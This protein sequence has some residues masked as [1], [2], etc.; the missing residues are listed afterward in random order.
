MSI[1]KLIK[2]VVIVGLGV[3]ILFFIYRKARPQEEK[4]LFKTEPLQ[5]RTITQVIDS[6]GTLEAIGTL[7]IGTLVNGIVEQLYAEENQTVKKGQLLAR[8]DDGQGD[9]NVKREAGL[10]KQ[11]EADL[12]YKEEFYGRQ[13]TLYENG[14]ISLDTFQQA[15]TSYEAAKG[16]LDAQKASY[17]QWL[18]QFNNKKILS[19]ID[20]VIIKKN[21]SLREAVN[22]FAPPTILYT[23]AEDIS[24]MKIE[25][26]IDETDIGLVKPGQEAKLFF[27]TY[28]HKK[29]RGIIK[30]ISS[31]PKDESANV[32][33]KAEIT[34]DNKHGLLKPGMTVHARIIV[35][36]AKDAFAVPGYL[37]SLNK[38]MIEAVAKQKEFAYKPLSKKEKAAFAKSLKNKDNPIKKLWVYE[39]DAFVQKP[40]QLGITD[41]AYFQ[42][43]AGLKGSEQILVD[44]DEPDEMAKMYSRLFGGGLGKKE[45]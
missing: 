35:A 8:I 40:V 1:S 13:K 24:K 27:A 7:N 19:P 11:A 16:A 22:N 21:V 2:W 3:L 43:I 14:H 44:I 4:Q 5:R 32:V 33:Y 12:A 41:N 18:L 9:T 42:I 17:E 15:E 28:P 20:G 10:V 30:Q 45:G 23:I 29:F 25:L 39:N 31:A 34:I 26:E 37:F 6:T 38:K 36:Q